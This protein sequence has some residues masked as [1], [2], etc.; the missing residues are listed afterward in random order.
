MSS[1]MLAGLAAGGVGAALAIGLVLSSH[2][3]PLLAYFLAL[4]LLFGLGVFS[5]ALAVR[6]LDLADYGQQHVA[7]A[8]AGLV[9]AS[10]TEM[11]DLVVRLLFASISAVSPTSALA[12]LILSRLPASSRAVLL[13]SMVVNVLLYLLYLLIVVGISSAIA[14]FAGRAKS[15]EALQALL[16]EQQPAF[17]PAAPRI[18]AEIPLD[19]DLLPFMGPEYSP[20]APVEEEPP[21]QQRRFEPGEPRAGSD[22]PFSDRREWPTNAQWPRPRERD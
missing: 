11:A 7:G 9:A 20:F 13:F 3:S 5:G 1:K 18:T 22:S 15:T 6:W 10:L 12:N 21:W 4:A 16:E 14:S 17:S 19:P 8:I 2:Y